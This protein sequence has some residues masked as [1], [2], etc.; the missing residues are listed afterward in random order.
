MIE[1]HAPGTPSLC[2]VAV[3]AALLLGG[4]VALLVLAIRT[5][6]SRV[7][8][9]SPRARGPGEDGSGDPAGLPPVREHGNSDH[10]RHRHHPRSRS[11]ETAQA[12]FEEQ[13]SQLESHS[14]GDT[15]WSYPLHRTNSTYMLAVN[16]DSPGPE[17]H[18]ARHPQ[19][20]FIKGLK[21]G[22]T[23]VAM[24]LNRCAQHYHI[25]LA[26]GFEDRA[27]RR[28]TVSP[29]ACHARNAALYFHHSRRAPW[30]SQC[31]PGA[32]F[33]TLLR[34]PISQALSWESMDLNR[35]YFIHYPM[36]NCSAADRHFAGANHHVAAT[37]KL[38]RIRDCVATEERSELTM[39]L[40]AQRV[41]HWGR[42]DCGPACSITTRW[43]SS[44]GNIK[45][46]TPERYIKILENKY[47]LVGVT[48]RLNEFLVLLALHFGWDSKWLY[49]R[50]C[51][52]QNVQ[53]HSR[54]FNKTHP[55]LFAKLQKASEVQRAA[56]QWAAAAFDRQVKALGDW[57]PAEVRRFEEGL[58]A[59]QEQHVLEKRPL[60]WRAYRYLDG[61]M[62]YC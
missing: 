5:P 60:K 42:T 28:G 38:N 6:G 32:K 27:A 26:T 25:K 59:F 40:V 61:E 2:Q 35:M 30:Q 8:S 23:S 10:H 21:V 18:Q 54:E 50:R 29:A 43:I 55:D 62:E 33:V 24:A 20:V 13:Y 45:Q 36:R 46:L 53:M 39:Q 57:F 22:G 34:E 19:L 56:H 11:N 7:M 48:E 17:Y 52:P 41:R 14:D 12:S 16:A 51:K 4:A 47:F 1:R 58:H 15:L 9:F 49:Y 44:I 3:R 37:E 31:V